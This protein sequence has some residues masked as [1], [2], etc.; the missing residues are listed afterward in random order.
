MESTSLKVNDLFFDLFKSRGSLNT[1][2]SRIYLLPLVALF[3]FYSNTGGDRHREEGAGSK[4]EEDHHDTH[5]HK[6]DKV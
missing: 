1:S 4:H 6:G 3:T 5:G 2:S